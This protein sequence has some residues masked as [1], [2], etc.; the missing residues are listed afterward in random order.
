[1]TLGHAA[2]GAGSPRPPLRS[3]LLAL[4]GRAV[5]AVPAAGVGLQQLPVGLELLRRLAVAHPVADIGLAVDAAVGDVGRA[6]PYLGRLLLSALEQD[7]ELVV[8]DVVSGPRAGT[9]S[10]FGRP[11]F[12]I[13]ARFSARGKAL[14]DLPFLS[15]G[16]FFLASTISRTSTPRSRPPS[17]LGHGL[18]AELVEAAEQRV[19]GAASAMNFRMCVVELAA[20]PFPRLRPLGGP[21]AR[22]ASCCRTR[23]CRPGCWRRPD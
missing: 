7:H 9:C 3:A 21:S 4:D 22:R 2:G 20:Q 14:V 17:G 11:A 5:V 1:M 10:A 15:L 12:S 18:V 23:A 6:G 13:I 19:A 16:S 8:L